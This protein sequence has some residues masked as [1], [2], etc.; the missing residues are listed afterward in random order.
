MSDHTSEPEVVLE[1]T[2][3]MD[4]ELKVKTLNDSVDS[5]QQRL[6]HLF[7]RLTALEIIPKS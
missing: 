5:L 1:D 2:R 7:Q 4:L 3:I 6:D